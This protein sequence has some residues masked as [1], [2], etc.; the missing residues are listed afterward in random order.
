MSQRICYKEDSKNA[1][2]TS[3]YSPI[4]LFNVEECGIETS[5]FQQKIKNEYN[6]LPDDKY[7]E[8][9]EKISLLE[10]LL[11]ESL[12][13]EISGQI[14]YGFYQGYEDSEDKI[15]FYV[16]NYLSSEDQK[17]FSSIISK[18]KRSAAQFKIEYINRNLI[19]VNRVP[20]TS[21]VQNKA[22]IADICKIDYR[23]APRIFFESND[24]LINEH[25]ILII[26]FIAN[27]IFHLHPV[28]ILD[29]VVHHTR[30]DAGGSN[31]PEGI[32]Q[33]GMDYIVSAL[34]VER[35]N[36]SGGESI[37][38]GCDKKTKIFSTTLQPG[39]GIFQPDRGSD[40]WHTVKPIN[41]VS[42]ASGYRSTIGFDFSLPN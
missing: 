13:S 20:L 9:F 41:V 35:F 24:A 31:A 12:L 1:V 5:D 21:F 25:L 27:K 26:K 37:I 23:K 2:L 28:K 8:R 4:E 40:L 33:D 17:I 7:V 15:A 22:Q 42:S 29:L 30:V 38:F 11:P 18:R 34:V 6:C 14:F 19:H 10:K 39:Q 16:K 32:H 36:I 3:I